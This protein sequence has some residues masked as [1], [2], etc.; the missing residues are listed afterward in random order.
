MAVSAH[1]AGESPIYG[2]GATH[3]T[4]ADDGAGPYITLKS[5]DPDTPDGGG[6]RFDLD[7]LEA[8]VRVARELIAAHERVAP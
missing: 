7:E 8:I 6:M 2:D 3:V 4:V 5:N 1:R